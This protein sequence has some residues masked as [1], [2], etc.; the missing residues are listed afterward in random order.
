MKIIVA[1]DAVLIRQGL[2]G[3]LHRQGHEV[4]VECSRADELENWCAEHP[5]DVAATD[6][7]IV[8]VRMPPGMRDDGLQ[9]AVAV[10]QDAPGLGVMVLSQ[11]ISPAYARILFRDAA[12]GGTGYL[13]KERVGD[14][15]E[16]LGALETVAAG[17][18]VIDPE[19]AQHL[20]RGSTGL[21]ALTPREREVLGMMARGLSNADIAEQLVVSHAAV[22]KH[23]SN[24]FVKLKLPPEVENRRVRAVLQYLAERS[25]FQWGERP[26]L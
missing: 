23:V 13:L 3:L 5:Q 16:F 15:A 12:L 1:D 22:A 2:V 9:A 7:L 14:V 10:R 25:A 26:I 8:D 6:V 11:Y 18:V 24:I 19:V 20:A 21:D 4:L 17:G